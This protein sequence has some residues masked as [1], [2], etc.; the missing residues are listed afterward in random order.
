MKKSLQEVREAFL[1]EVFNYIEDCTAT[2]SKNEVAAKT[3]TFSKNEW[4]FVEASYIANDI[5]TGTCSD[6]TADFICRMLADR[7]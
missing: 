2:F 3:A 1:A 5:R 4:K 7:V 6:F